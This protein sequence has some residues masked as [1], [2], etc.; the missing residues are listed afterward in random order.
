MV[1]SPLAGLPAADHKYGPVGLDR[2]PA[3]LRD[4]RYLPGKYAIGILN[5]VAIS[6]KYDWPAVRV[7]VIILRN[8]T[9]AAS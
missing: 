7:A 5:L 8:T 4:P 1:Y 9:S 3:L 2:V 6:L